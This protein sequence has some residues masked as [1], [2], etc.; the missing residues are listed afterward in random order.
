MEKHF[1]YMASKMSYK[2]L[3]N[4]THARQESNEG[5]ARSSFF[6]SLSSNSCSSS[7]ILN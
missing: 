7:A 5:L 3:L 1:K 4:W 6:Y 2:A